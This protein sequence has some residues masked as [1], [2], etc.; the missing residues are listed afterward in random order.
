MGKLCHSHKSGEKWWRTITQDTCRYL[1]FHWNLWSACEMRS[2]LKFTLLTFHDI[3]SLLPVYL[4]PNQQRNRGRGNAYS[5]YWY[6]FSTFKTKEIIYF[7][8]AHSD[9]FRKESTRIK[10]KK[11]LKKLGLDL[12]VLASELGAL[13]SELW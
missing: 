9:Q 7:K 3:S 5:Y 2:K 10:W 8:V 4:Y 11:S 6:P 12:G 13:D 1:M